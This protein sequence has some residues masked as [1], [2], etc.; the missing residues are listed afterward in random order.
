MWATHLSFVMC[1]KRLSQEVYPKSPTWET[2]F[3]ELGINRWN[4]KERLSC[5][6]SLLLISCGVNFF[7]HLSTILVG[8]MVGKEKGP[9]DTAFVDKDAE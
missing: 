8:N 7:F 5:G 4:R 9:Q 1:A 6:G 2:L 3:Q